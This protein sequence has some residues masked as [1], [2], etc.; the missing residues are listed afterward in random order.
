MSV[1]LYSALM[2][3]YA[4]CG[5]Y[6]KACDL[7]AQIRQEGLEPDA[8][9]YG[10]LMKFSVECGRT[11]LSQELF[12]K[13]P[14]VDIHNYMSLIR[15][16][17]RDRDVDRAFAVLEKLKA[18]AIPADIAAYNCVV[19]AC[20]LAGD[21]K[22]AHGLLEQVKQTGCVDIVTYNTILKGY[23]SNGDLAKASEIF[24]E[25]EEAGFQPNDVS[26]NCLIN[27][28]VCKGAFREIWNIVEM[29]ESNGVT[30]DRYTISTVMKALKKAQDPRDVG[31][32]LSL[33][34]RSGL[35]VCSDEVMLNTVLETCIKH[36]RFDRTSAIVHAFPGSEMH[37]SEHTYGTLI[38]ACNMLKRLDKCWEFW[39]DM[40]DRRTMVPNAIVV[41]CMLDALVCNGRV[42]DAVELFTV[43]KTKVPVNT[44]LYST[45]IK[46]FA[47]SRRAA[48]AMEL[49]HE[50]QEAR[51]PM[52]SV[53]YNT[54]IDSQARVGEVTSVQ[55]LFASMEPD[56]VKP[57]A[58]TYSTVV[59]AYCIKGDLDKALKVFR[60]VQKNSMAKD[61]VVYNTMLDG[62][63]RHNRMDLA[64][65][66]L[67]DM[68]KFGIKPSSFT[69]GILVKMYGRRH[70]L[71]KA[72][73]A[74]RQMPEKYGITVNSQ[75]NTCLMCACIQENNIDLAFQVFRHWQAAG[76][77]LDGKAFGVLISGCV[78][79][80]RVE[81]AT[82][83][84]EEACDLISKS[85]SHGKSQAS[86]TLEKEP[87]EQLFG[88]L[89]QRGQEKNIAVPLME[90]L[91]AAGV[92]MNGRLVS[93][94]IA[95]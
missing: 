64:D 58:I 26:Y 52:N 59:K 76:N 49:W 44:V 23:C 30:V 54:L 83:L 68:E 60:D 69:L 29:M 51:L 4:Y 80:G 5:L 35:D 45:L 79:Q 13:A 31:K 85:T 8:L 93:S 62:A 63:T 66:I 41:G 82:Q 33:L 3:V 15:A 81:Q 11:E 28:A 88:A 25:M 43:W 70:Q 53:V 90:K 61:C 17:G 14:S 57:D 19:D 72:F 1:S 67:Q 10:C 65:I 78:R 18:S 46:G 75:V 94:A 20:V 16:A 91:R 92:P 89:S 2:K 27:A 42:D 55:K 12:E 9:M 32:A 56:G 87:L 40:T 37:A 6:H 47:T 71:D 7:Y 86:Q 22:R 95:K 50:M 74:V 77:V 84:V 34:D 21:M 24:K 48:E 38:K 73:E 39:A 36:R